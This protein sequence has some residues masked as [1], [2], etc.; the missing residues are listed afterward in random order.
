METLWRKSYYAALENL[1]RS[2][3]SQC[4]SSPRSENGYNKPFEPDR[5]LGGTGLASPKESINTRSS[6]FML[7]GSEIRRCPVKTWTNGV[8]SSAT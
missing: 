4:L 3:D 5:M 1:L 7:L 2:R 8:G 6:F